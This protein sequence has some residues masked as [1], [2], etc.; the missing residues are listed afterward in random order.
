MDLLRLNRPL[1]PDEFFMLLYHL[2]ET[3]L[4]NCVF[5]ESSDLREKHL[6]P[7]ERHYSEIHNQIEESIK[8][9]LALFDSC[10]QDTVYYH[11]YY[12]QLSQIYLLPIFLK[13]YE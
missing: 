5:E 3:I 11:L 1:F 6:K 7:L 2:V 10:V 12:A 13:S 4:Y 8:Q 9:E